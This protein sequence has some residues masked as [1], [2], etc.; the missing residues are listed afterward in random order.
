MGK[1]V[2]ASGTPTTG[3]V[4]TYNGSSVAWATPSGG[5]GGG[6]LT[7]VATNLTG[8]GGA[9]TAS[10][11]TASVSPTANALILLS[12][13]VRNGASVDPTTPTVSGNGLTWV[14]VNSITSDNTSGS[15]RMNFLFRAMG[16]SPTTGAVTITFGETETDA[17]WSVDQFTNTLTSG[18]N[19]SGAI[20]QNVTANDLTGSATSL[21]VTLAAFAASTN[22]TFG[23]F[24]TDGATGATAGTG[25]AVLGHG[26]SGTN[27]TT[28]TEFKNS[29]TTTVAF[30]YGVTAGI[31]GIAVEIAAASS[32]PITKLTT[33]GSGAAT[34]SV[35]TL[36]IPTPPTAPVTS[37]A[38]RTG[39]VTLTADDTPDGTTNK[40]YTA[41]EK[42]KLAGVATGATANSSDATL[43]NRA[44]HTGT[45]AEST[46][47][48]LVTDLA[49]KQAAL[50]LTT[51]GTT[52]AATLSAGTLNIP[53][54]SAGGGGD[55]STN[56]AVSVDS[57]V[58]LFSS[59]TGKILKRATITGLAKLVA[60]VLSAAVSGTDYAPGTSALATGIVKTTTSTGALSIAVSG[61][62]YALPNANTTGSAATLT[63][64]RTI[65]G[66]S[67]NG[68]ANITIA[69]TNLS[70]TANIALDTN[71]LT[72]TNKRIT[73]RVITATSSATPTPTGD[74][75]D[76]WYLSTLTVA[77]TFAAPTGT[78]T[79]G[80]PLIIRIKSVAAQTLGWNAIYLASGVAALPT[81]S[82]AGKTVTC[83]FTYDA[84]AVK[85]V[86]MAVDATGY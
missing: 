45:Q 31:G 8:G 36:N 23:F 14:L 83:G 18:T 54:Y 1:H 21:T 47:T 2:Q 82:V 53:Q 33:T 29:S 74:T 78:P 38:G 16:A 20:V 5:G 70:N 19:G 57:E 43:E 24:G 81:T 86:L 77:A 72:L 85:W 67:F 9:A 44:N 55:A 62:D 27:V 76:I 35:D 50:S 84:A 25:L 11:V 13:S 37:V 52:G 39:I 66:V 58:A 59:T 46:I 12:V 17:S 48:N 34:L 30:S 40:A 63:T 7:V 42:T 41:T 6:P 60:G 65:A 28:D 71:T 4:P 26:A 22:A 69:S 79:D 61:T 51:T 80:Q 56:T 32:V 3:Q 10:A 49:A 68:S 75:A 73:K 64:A 15:R